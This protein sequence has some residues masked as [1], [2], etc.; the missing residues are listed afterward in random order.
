MDG[1]GYALESLSVP[2]KDK[3]F[4]T[5]FFESD[6]RM[7]QVLQHHR[8]HPQASLSHVTVKNE[9]RLLDASLPP[10]VWIPSFF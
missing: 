10:S 5:V 2:I 9:D 3:S 6:L 7:R 8:V 4:F 1:A